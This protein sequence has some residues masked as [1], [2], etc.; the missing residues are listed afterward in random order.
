MPR[1][2]GTADHTMTT[3]DQKSTPHGLRVHAAAS[4]SAEESSATPSD[5]SSGPTASW[6]AHHPVTATHMVP[7][8]TMAEKQNTDP[9]PVERMRAWK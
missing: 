8:R 4:M 2:M 1:M 6:A 7:P 9:V 5:T 3:I